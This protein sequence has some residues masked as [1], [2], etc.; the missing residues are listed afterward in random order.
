MHLFNLAISSKTKLNTKYL[1]T[2]KQPFS[3]TINLENN[4]NAKNRKKLINYLCTTSS[5]ARP[6][7]HLIIHLFRYSSSMVVV[8][9]NL[10]SFWFMCYEK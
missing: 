10:I 5:I 6:K 7:G 1:S 3:F 8:H 2:Q 9:Y 4:G